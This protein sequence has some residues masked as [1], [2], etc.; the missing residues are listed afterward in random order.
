M[1]LNT[2]LNKLKIEPKLIEFSETMAVIENHY[3]F[4][5]T[6]FANGETVNEAG[7][8]NG[9]CKIFAFAKLHELTVEQT[10]ACFGR[11][12]RKDVL[13]HPMENDHQNIR[14]FM[15]SGWSGVHFSSQ[16][17]QLK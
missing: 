4:T 16:A 1:A 5:A 8:N 17:L 14:S 6:E 13:L 12:Y 11:Y 7:K 2:F 3:E 15:V 9:S 10:L